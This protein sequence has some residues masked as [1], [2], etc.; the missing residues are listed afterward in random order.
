MVVSGY[1][2]RVTQASVASVAALCETSIVF[3]T[4][5]WAAFLKERLGWTRHVAAAVVALAAA[6]LRLA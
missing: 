6:V 5:L 4:V 3:A 2:V 1:R